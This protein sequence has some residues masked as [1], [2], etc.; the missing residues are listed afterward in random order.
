MYCVLCQSM[1]SFHYFL[2][3]SFL[4]STNFI[5]SSH[6]KSYLI[7]F[8]CCYKHILITMYNKIK[9][10]YTIYIYKNKN[11]ELNIKYFNNLKIGFQY[12]I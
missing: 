5:L 1:Y 4:E 2:T 3:I 6:R 11:T 10:T 8:C 7:R 12:Q 9:V